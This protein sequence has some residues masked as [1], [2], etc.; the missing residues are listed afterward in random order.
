MKDRVNVGDI[1]Y[2]KW[3]CT[4]TYPVWFRITKVN[5]KTAV[6]ERL[7]SKM[8]QTTD[9]GYGQR[10][11]EVPSGEARL[12]DKPHIIRIAKD[13]RLVTGSGYDRF[14]LNKW[15]GQ[16]IYADYMD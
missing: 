6:A 3:Y 8:V 12:G 14:L 13:G 7:S 5:A 16:P 4:M 11:Y 9:G 1:L 15:D 2:G 10:G